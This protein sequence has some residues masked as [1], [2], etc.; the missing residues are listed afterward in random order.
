MTAQAHNR[1]VFSVMVL[2]F[3]VNGTQ[4]LDLV[5]SFQLGTLL[6]PLLLDATIICMSTKHDFLARKIYC[7]NTFDTL[8]PKSTSFGGG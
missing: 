6:K 5:W 8:L 4:T 3:A 2:E 7:T 1:F